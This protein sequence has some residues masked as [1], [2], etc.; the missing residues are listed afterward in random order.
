MLAPPTR[1][2]WL[3]TLDASKLKARTF[4]QSK[5]GHIQSGQADHSE[6]TETPA[7]RAQ[8]IEDEVLGRKRQPIVDPEEER[9]REEEEERD[10]RIKEHVRQ[11]RGPSLMDKHVAN[12]KDGDADDPSK[13]AF[14]Y[15]KD[16]AGGSVGF[17]ERSAM[18]SRAKDLE[19]KYS[20]GKYL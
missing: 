9:R 20:G 13:R 4:N 2:D 5:S 8:R 16:I 3:N 6:W 11:T 14:D 1:A 18:M 15:Q 12:K 7:E 17:K 19:S 10:R